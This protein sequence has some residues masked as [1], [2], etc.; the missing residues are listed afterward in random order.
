MQIKTLKFIVLLGMN[1]A[2]ANV[3]GQ[4]WYWTKQAD[5]ST[6]T[7]QT[8]SQVAVDRNNN[9]IYTGYFE[10]PRMSFGPFG[11]D[12]F[13]FQ[14]DFLAKYTTNGVPVWSRNSTALSTSA[15]VYG[16]S[17]A[18]DRNNAVLE[19]GYY[20]DSI[21][22]GPYH[23]TA[24][25]S[26]SNTYLAK[27]DANGNIL[28]ASS[29]KLGVNAYPNY[30]YSVNADKQNNIY[31]AGY[32]DDTIIFGRD[33]LAANG[34]DMY[35]VKYSPAGNVIW[36]RC[37]RLG[38]GAYTYGLSVASD[39]SG[40]AYVAGNIFDSA[41]FGKIGM[42]GNGTASV[43][44][45]KYDSSGNVKWAQNTTATPGQ[46]L[47]TPV[48]VDKS[49]NVYLG[50][51][52]TNA[53][54]TLGSS[55]IT[56]G[57][58]G[59][60]SNAGLIKYTPN[61]NVIWATCADFISV[62]E[63]CVIVESA[64]TT[65]RCNNVYW[66]GL[67]SDTFGVGKVKVTVAGG[68]THQSTPFA[69]VIKLDSNSNPIAGAAI[70]NENGYSFSN[71][72]ACDSLSKVLFA[73]EIADPGPATAIIGN[74]TVKRYLTYNTCFLS[75]FAVVPTISNKNGSDSICY[76]DSIELSISS[77]IGT[78]YTWST[79][80][81]T[82]SIN[83]KP[84]VTTIYSIIANN[85]CLKDTS[86]IT[87]TVT[88]NIIPGIKARPDTVCKGDT[89]IINASGGTTYKWSTVQTTDTIRVVPK[90]DSTF[91][92]TIYSGNCSKDTTIKIIVIPSFTAVA[93]A[94][95]DT[96][97]PGDSALLS[98]SGGTTYRWSNGKT[99]TSI[100]VTPLITTT[101]LV[102]AYSGKCSNVDSVKV[103]VL[104]ATTATVSPND[105]ICPKG[106][107]ILTVTGSGGNVAY[108]WS[109]GQTTSSITV[110]PLSNTTY[111]VTVYGKCDSVKKMVTVIVD[112][113]PLPIIKGNP[114]K[115]KG[116]K[117]T[118][119]VTGGVTYKWSNGSTSTTYYTGPINADS[120]ITVT[121]YN[122]IGC[123]HDTTFKITVK[124]ITDTVNKPI[125]ACRGSMV[126][127]VAN[128]IGAGPF[129]YKWSPGGETTDSISVVD[130]AAT[131]YTVTL[132]K[133]GCANTEITDVTPYNPPLNACCSTIIF[134]GDDT[135]ITA[136]GS[137]IKEYQW[138]DSANVVCLNPPLCNEV[139]VTP[140]VTTTYTVIGT[141]SN[142]CQSQRIV[143]IIVE[144]PCFN[145]TVPNVF[146]PNNPGPNGV[147]NV[148]YIKTENISGWS[149]YIYDRWGK[150]M[151]KSTN[152]DVYWNGNTESG[153]KAPDGVYYY[154]IK[155]TCQ[156]NTYKKDGF[157]Q[158][159]R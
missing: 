116:V 20:S 55:T 8:A 70:R 119:T 62:N 24:G 33:T 109:S 10:G 34:T 45:A 77:V 76:G 52:F 124:P 114:L 6:G 108:K 131:N 133:D 35:L 37:A 57:D 130:T 2:A 139:K 127:L 118:L 140:T 153:S 46:E 83:V 90:A 15:F 28:W 115:C 89:A 151:F 159:I 149:I 64:V 110:S 60:C 102:E 58:P 122:A 23:L 101:Y 87:V 19:S 147:N 138:V 63:V 136:S 123:S 41:Y 22:F 71:Y 148:F 21:A 74:D 49:N 50:F 145:F 141:D 152:P 14:A 144:I 12:N 18:T 53:A 51:Q 36:A 120:T 95:P 92:V 154:I 158:L 104:T 26:G 157:L 82:D 79:G 111:T 29:P 43:Y 9:A 126:E 129:T 128:P 65:D 80:A 78:T 91:T 61:G 84:L 59:S 7:G 113:V 88:P 134:P 132:F 4:T 75:K 1:I 86:Y 54:I 47:P 112:P 99:T 107:A 39:D 146:T 97:C 73:S 72:L 98:A 44:I 100:W 125:V 150:E 30:N 143:T 69:Y 96:V 93:T 106:T 94:R 32:F 25:N 40:N 137:T 68:S 42:L 31:I 67:C 3:S 16:M 105:T 38:P 155:G 135:I 5:S 81:T 117:D 66:S 13:G 156:N 27:Y 48:V 142:G 85:G 17:V 103:N 121:A 56:D 11:I